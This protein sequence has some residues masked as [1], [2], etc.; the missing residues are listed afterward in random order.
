[1]KKNPDGYCGLGGTGVK[2]PGLAPVNPAALP[3]S[4]KAPLDA[5]SLSLKRQLI[6]FE[7]EDC[8]YCKPFKSDVL[9]HWKAE[10]PVARSL[11]GQAPA[12]RALEKALLY[13]E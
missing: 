8:A 3:L 11:S 10:V 9:D 13:Q 6:A 4:A 12:G 5:K 7:A 2:Y 1:M